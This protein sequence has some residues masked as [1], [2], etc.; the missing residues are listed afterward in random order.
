MSIPARI[1]DPTFAL[2]AKTGNFINGST[3]TQLTSRSTAVTINALSGTITTNTTSL[4]I[5]TSAEFTVNN[6]E[7]EINDV[8]LLSQ[9][10][11]SSN[12]AGT[13]GVTIVHVLT[14][15]AGSFIVSVQ[16]NSTTTP[17]TGA[18]VINFLVQK[19]STT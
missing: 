10:S 12:V 11:G 3:V 17:E 15:A 16:N 18:I 4:A 2:G 13:A 5:A 9:R 7:V 19:A 8:I 14:V 6:T 1:I